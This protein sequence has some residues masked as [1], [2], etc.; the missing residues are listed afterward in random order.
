MDNFLR[1]ILISSHKLILTLLTEAGL[2]G[3]TIF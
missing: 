3:Q 2:E 1:E